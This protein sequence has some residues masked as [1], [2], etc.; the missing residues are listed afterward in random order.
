MLQPGL[1]G[2]ATREQKPFLPQVN[3]TKVSYDRI[4]GEN[5]A[6]YQEKH[7]EVPFHEIIDIIRAQADQDYLDLI[8]R[9]CINDPNSNPGSKEKKGLSADPENLHPNMLKVQGS[10]PSAPKTIIYLDRNNTP[11]IWAD[12]KRTVL[13]NSTTIAG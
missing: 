12:I 11:D 2:G 1:L 13:E 4:L 7:P 9:H 10:C 5:T 8:A 6:S 3:Y